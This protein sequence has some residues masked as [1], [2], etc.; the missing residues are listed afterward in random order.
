MLLTLDPGLHKPLYVQIR[1]QIRD[2]I[3]G[4]GLKVGDR[5]EP[6]R[7]LARRLGVHRTTVGNAYAEL[8][9]EGLIQGAVGR[10]TFVSPLANQVKSGRQPARRASNDFF[11]ESLFV[12][13]ARDDA[14]NRLMASAYQ[15]GV[16]CFAVSHAA[17]ELSPVDLVR[18][19][20][21][22]ILRREG[23]RI[24][25]YGASDGYPPL[26]RYLQGSLR[27]DGIPVE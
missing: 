22:R 24:L 21:D 8:E 18:R 20:T 10:G 7:E 9:A 27:R 3:V 15:P 5:L 14:L 26:K 25:Q 12:E 6:S 1:D 19:A 17:A 16:I 13:E 11:W 23:A 2:R 4:G